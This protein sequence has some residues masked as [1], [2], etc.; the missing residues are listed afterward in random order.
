MTVK[1]FV[2]M[3]DGAPGFRQSVRNGRLAAAG[4][5]GYPY[6]PDRTSQAQA[7]DPGRSIKF[8]SS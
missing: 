7:R 4:T 2:I 5:P 3:V 6:C 1:S 8:N